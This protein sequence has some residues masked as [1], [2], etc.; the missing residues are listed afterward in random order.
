MRFNRD[1]EF[2]NERFKAP[3][4]LLPV[5]QG[6]AGS[7]Q[8]CLRRSSWV[9]R[10]APA[11]VEIGEDPSLRLPSAISTR[12]SSNGMMLL[13]D[14]LCQMEPR[15]SYT[16]DRRKS[17]IRPNRFRLVVKTMPP[18]FP[19]VHYIEPSKGLLMKLPPNFW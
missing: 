15:S 16:T 3:L 13:L 14:G 5:Q 2:G 12:V 9:D 4:H 1:D 6:R 10:G 8:E 11:R 7:Q 19:L 17:L 18:L